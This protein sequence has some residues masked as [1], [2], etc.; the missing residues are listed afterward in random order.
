MVVVVF[1]VMAVPDMLGATPPSCQS[2]VTVKL[3]DVVA[4]WVIRV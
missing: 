2:R 3:L 1:P 4:A